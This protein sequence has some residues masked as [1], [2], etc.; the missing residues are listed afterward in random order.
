MLE[1]IRGHKL[2]KSY[3]L[4]IDGANQVPNNEKE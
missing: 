1:T 3:N 2:A 4:L